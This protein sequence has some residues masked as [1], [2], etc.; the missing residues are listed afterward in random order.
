[1]PTKTKTR[2]SMAPIPDVSESSPDVNPEPRPG[3]PMETAPAPIAGATATLERQTNRPSTGKRPELDEY[4]PVYGSK[5]PGKGLSGVMRRAAYKLP[6]YRPARW[7][8][9][10][11]ADR[12]DVIESYA[13]ELLSTRRGLATL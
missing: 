4:T 11:A 6:D 8:T 9:L 5:Q 7:M 2:N 12:V 13:A 10:L 1:M 3:V